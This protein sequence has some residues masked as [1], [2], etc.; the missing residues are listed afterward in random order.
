[1]ATA[2]TFPGVYTQII[3][4]SFVTPAQSNFKPG[5]IGV[6][7]KGAF[8]TPI[9]IRSLN[10]FV[11]TFGRP[12]ATAY[13]S[14]DPKSDPVGSGYFLSNAVA[15]ITDMTDGIVV[16]RVGN[17]YTNLPTQATGTSGAG[18][19]TTSVADAKYINALLV[20]GAVYVALSET[21]KKSTV[22]VEVD[23]ADEGTGVV[24]LVSGTLGA[25][26]T[27]A[28]VGFSAYSGAAW[29][30]EG[31]LYAYSYGTGVSDTPVAVTAAGAVTGTKNTYQ[32]VVAGDPD[33]V[34]IGSV[35]K[36]VQSTKATTYEVRVAKK[37]G[38]TIYLETSDITRVGYQSSALQD[39]Y[40]NAALYK[41]NTNHKVPY[42]Y[43]Q[44]K[45]PGDWA[46]GGSAKV[47]LFVQVRPGSNAGTKKLEVFWD[48][49]LVETLDNI[50]DTATATAADSYE[51]VIALSS[52]IALVSRND[53]LG[54]EH[55]ANTCAPWDSGY[56]TFP[57]LSAPVAMPQ[58]AVNAGVVGTTDTGG[59]FGSGVTSGG[60]AGYNGQNAQVSDFV[61][62]INP[63]DDSATGL[64][65]FEDTDTVS[66]N[67]LAAPMDDIDIS[68]MQEMRRV[69]KRVNAVALASVPSG[70]NARQAIDWHNGAGLYS[71]N[72]RLDDPNIAVYWNWFVIT[73]PFTGTKKLVPPEL[74]ALRCLAATFGVD[75]PWNAAAG[76]TRGI[77]PE[78]ED[79]EFIR[80]AA[81]VKQAM[82]GNGNSVNPIL[83]IDNSFYLWGERTLQRAESKLT[84]LHSV[85]LV[86]WV[87]TGLASVGKRFT[88]DPNDPELLVQ[89]RLSFT[90][91][92]DKVRNER[93]IEDYEL[94]CDERN[95]PPASRNT[96][97]VI[98]D[99]SLIPTDIMERMFIKATVRESGAQLNS[100]S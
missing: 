64:K 9:S 55:A 52:Y 36:I 95:N 82:Y 13:A 29:A 77:I 54:A 53:A 90:E 48:A 47:G 21:G 1:M 80:V 72:G 20:D 3:D 67:V 28:V 22:N 79:L 73:D 19:F 17:R 10:E 23:S 78:A 50:S 31:V 32:F 40:T 38:T 37:V 100:V 7:A 15:M 49:A 76:L 71:G 26:Y 96:R 99:L 62:T 66:V 27:A 30:A 63:A 51:S 91:F 58:G 2:K 65:A 18:T 88:F 75:K 5:L 12:L 93:G 43:L 92:L 8:D 87:V 70:L 60:A 6:A 39:T 16:V 97:N 57:A 41:V 45:T 69:A 84:A 35:Y 89:I 56:Y 34:D 81:D 44:G 68:I 83:K 4:R 86:N 24:T 33:Q 94:V 74:G 42:L 59:Q 61:G 85:I 11:T 98:V 46:N 14:T 25:D